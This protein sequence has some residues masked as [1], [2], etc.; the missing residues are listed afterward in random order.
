MI[1]KKNTS[2]LM[3]N[4]KIIFLI[5]IYPGTYTC[6]THVRITCPSSSYKLHLSRIK[7]IM[8]M[9]LLWVSPYSF[10]LYDCVTKQAN[11]LKL[12]FKNGVVFTSLHKKYQSIFTKYILRDTVLPSDYRLYTYLLLSQLPVIPQMLSKLY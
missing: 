10:F 7:T 6:N 4:N 5:W 9:R 8:K 12:S 1:I 11:S 2:K 3:W